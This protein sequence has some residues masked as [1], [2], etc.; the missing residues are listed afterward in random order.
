MGEMLRGTQAVAA[1]LSQL[2]G[3]APHPSMWS[4][5]LESRT[6]ALAS[7]LASMCASL[8]E[9]E[10]VARLLH[11]EAAPELAGILSVDPASHKVPCV[12]Y[13]EA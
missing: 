3:G 10:Q 9:L 5:A 11:L 12:R 8:G 4:P 1:R 13:D 2:L 6:E 7:N